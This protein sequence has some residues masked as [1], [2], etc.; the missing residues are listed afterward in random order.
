[1][2]VPGQGKQ[3]KITRAH[4]DT[5]YDHLFKFIIIG[6]SGTWR[7]SN[8]WVAFN[9]YRPSLA[10]VGK[11]SIMTRYCDG[12]FSTGYHTTIGVDFKIKMINLGGLTIKIQSTLHQLWRFGSLISDNASSLTHSMGHFWTR[13]F[14]ILA[15]GLLQRS[16]WH[17]DGLRHLRCAQFCQYHA[18]A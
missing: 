3:P 18:M 2:T 14:P 4:G 7:C 9:A 8:G 6:D 11:T 16:T 12:G 17:L 1:M 15:T 10:G 13:T 5:K